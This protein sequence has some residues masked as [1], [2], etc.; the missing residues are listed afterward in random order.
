MTTMT[1]YVRHTDGYLVEGKLDVYFQDAE[2]WA[3]LREQQDLAA[4]LAPRTETAVGRF[5]NWRRDRDSNPGDA[6]V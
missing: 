3:W 6:T 1:E 5:M 4:D 2:F